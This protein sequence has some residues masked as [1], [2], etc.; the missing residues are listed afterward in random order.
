M[1]NEE[2]A[3]QMERTHKAVVKA[4]EDISAM[5]EYIFQKVSQN[6]EDQCPND[7]ENI[8]FFMDSHDRLAGQLRDAV[9]A[10]IR[11]RQENELSTSA[12]SEVCGDVEALLRDMQSLRA[13]F[14][15]WVN[16]VEGVP[17]WSQH[18]EDLMSL[19]SAEEEAAEKA[20]AYRTGGGNLVKGSK[21]QLEGQTPSP[22][23]PSGK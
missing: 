5:R 4:L 12:L 7:W 18:L 22:D 2:E 10:A 1:E 11:F 23:D 21:T 19:P 16:K 17:T 3:R 14:L 15:N 6:I 8:E 20:E 13:N 9:G